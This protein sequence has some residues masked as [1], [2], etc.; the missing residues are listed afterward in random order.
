M[1][2]RHCDRSG[3]TLQD[4]NGGYVFMK[5]VSGRFSAFLIDFSVMEVLAN[6][7]LFVT[8]LY[9]KYN[10]TYCQ[11]DITGLRVKCAECTD[12]D[13]C[14]QVSREWLRFH[15]ISRDITSIIYLFT[16]P[17]P[18]FPFDLPFRPHPPAF[19]IICLFDN[20]KLSD[21]AA[22]ASRKNRFIID[23]FYHHKRSLRPVVLILSIFWLLFL[24]HGEMNNYF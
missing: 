11:E 9:A 6:S 16:L 4:K 20:V 14:L 18:Q 8:D 23:S 19:L 2:W 15:F 7:E 5:G 1:R 17:P 10:C 13:L 21:S 22:G 12:F 3:R 24:F